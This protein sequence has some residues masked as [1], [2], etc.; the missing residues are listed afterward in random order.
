MKGIDID[1]LKNMEGSC[2]KAADSVVCVLVKMHV[3]VPLFVIFLEPVWNVTP[4]DI[5][6]ELPHT[7]TTYSSSDPLLVSSEDT[8]TTVGC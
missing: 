8:Y 1:Q 3:T 5:L 6:H 4:S 7:H 2:V